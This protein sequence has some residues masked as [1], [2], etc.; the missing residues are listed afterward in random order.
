MPPTGHS[1]IA[2]IDSLTMVHESHELAWTAVGAVTVEI[3]GRAWRVDPAR[4]LWIPGG[5]PHTVVPQ[6]DALLLPVFFTD[7]TPHARH[8]HS[9]VRTDELDALAR[10]LAQRTL[11]SPS[12]TKRAKERLR[13]IIKTA[14]VDIPLPADPRAR[15]V[16]EALLEDPGRP[17]TLEDWARHVHTSAKTL[18]RCFATE[19][20]MRFPDWRTRVRLHTAR[21]LL[22]GDDRVQTIARRVGY[23]SS[24]AFTE[25]FRRRYGETPARAR[26][27]A[28]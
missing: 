1:P 15:V 16:A 28:R 7:D 24:T 22:S 21:R 3:E 6:S 18:Q 23:A 27:A 14:S 17:D 11:I 12:Q 5:I 4:A 19:T 8:P 25:A 20:G 9:V 13:T 26:E 10:A 2:M